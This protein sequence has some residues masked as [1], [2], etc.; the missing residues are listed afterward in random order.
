MEP[1]AQVLGFI[2]W[3]IATFVLGL[4]LGIFLSGITPGYDIVDI[5]I[6]S[7]WWNV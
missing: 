7:H 3:Q 1:L 2:G 5:G 4:S 6:N